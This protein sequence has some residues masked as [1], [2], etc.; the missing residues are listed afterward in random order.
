MLPGNT[1]RRLWRSGYCDLNV[2]QK[3]SYR[4]TKPTKRASDKPL[5][6]LQDLLDFAIKTPLERQI[7][8]DWFG[9]SLKNEHLKPKWAI[10]LFSETKGT[11]KST[12][13]ELGQALFGEENTANENGIEGLTQRFAA[14]SL[15]KKFV[16][17]EEVKLSSHSDAG[18]KMKDYITGDHATVDIKHQTKQTLPLKCAFMMT[19]NHKPTWLEGGER[20]YFIID[21]DHDGHAH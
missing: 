18:N 2:W 6:S 16:K 7:L 19:T 11:G 20:R 8:L 15:S 3:P 10:F 9:W 21:M 12:L 14:D 4:N 1:A 5:G 17:V 13:M